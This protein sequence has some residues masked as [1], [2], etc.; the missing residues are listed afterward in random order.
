M[1]ANFQAMG[2]D[3]KYMDVFRRLGLED[4]FRLPPCG[5]DIQ[6]SYELMTSIDAI[7]TAKLTDMEGEKVVVTANENLVKEALH[8]KDGY[9]DMKHRLMKE[10]H[11]RYFL[12]NKA[13]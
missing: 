13:R 1:P 8:F 11:N 4:Y 7:D 12:N 3:D 2:R 9:E 5:V 10:D 6:R